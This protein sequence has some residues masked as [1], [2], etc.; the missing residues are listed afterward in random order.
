MSAY[1]NYGKNSGNEKMEAYQL[2]R[3]KRKRLSIV[4]EKDGTIQV[5]A[6]YW[7]PK[8]Q[9]DQFI[10]QKADWIEEKRSEFHTLQQK[11]PVHSFQEGDGFLIFGEAYRLVFE[12]SVGFQA[13][14]KESGD[15]ERIELDQKK[16]FLVM[17]AAHP[18]PHYV[19]KCLRFFMVQIV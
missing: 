8:Y 17:E 12:G 13:G 4:I 1:K 3:S 6:P 7:L 15:I 9:I 10:R 5:K 2:T 18:E 14:E 11:K 16:K 19:K